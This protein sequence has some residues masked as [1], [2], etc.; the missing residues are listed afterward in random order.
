MAGDNGTPELM[1]FTLNQ[2]SEQIFNVAAMFAEKDTPELNKELDE[3]SKGSSSET[4]TTIDIDNEIN[5]DEFQRKET[6]CSLESNI[7]GT[8]IKHIKDFC[9]S[10]SQYM[11]NS[12]NDLMTRNDVPEVDYDTPTYTELLY[13]S[14]LE[15]DIRMQNYLSRLDYN[16]N[17]WMKPL[18]NPL[19]N[20]EQQASSVC[21]T[22]TTS[23]SSK[24]DDGND[25]SVDSYHQ[26]SH[27]KLV[28][29]YVNLKFLI[30]I[31]I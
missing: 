11:Q 5:F 26:P 30:I 25:L 22:M 2:T 24:F 15:R 18:E 14:D 1:D 4:I 6:T 17:N 27:G 13:Y 20:T 21:E 9:F 23:T 31:T 28:L 29:I 10:Q 3:S 12:P 19:I 16:N 7:S 8:H